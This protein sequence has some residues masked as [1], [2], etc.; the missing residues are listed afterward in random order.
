MGRGDGAG[1]GPCGQN[2]VGIGVCRAGVAGRVGISSPGEAST[3]R[4]GERTAAPGCLGQDMDGV[5]F[6]SVG[7]SV[8]G[9]CAQALKV[10]GWGREA[11]EALKPS[12][13]DSE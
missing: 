3:V 5:T 8:C 1:K 7:K 2:R 10:A 12:L 11:G 9:A 6:F 4:K 13:R